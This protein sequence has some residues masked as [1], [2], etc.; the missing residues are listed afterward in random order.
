[1]CPKLASSTVPVLIKVVIFI[2]SYTVLVYEYLLYQRQNKFSSESV[3]F[4]LM[5]PLITP[6]LRSRIRLE[7]PLLG[8]SRS[9]F[10]CWPEPRAGAAIFKAAPAASFWQAKKAKRKALLLLQNMT[11][12]DSLTRLRC[13]FFG[14]NI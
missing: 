7:P 14:L 3:K 6:V 1:M 10:F 12:R 13:A 9:Q 2:A 5:F 8:W 4:S 11:E